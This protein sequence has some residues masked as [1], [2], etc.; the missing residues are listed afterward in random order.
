MK[1]NVAALALSLAA[2]FAPLSQAHAS[3]T[4]IAELYKE[5][6]SEERRAGHILGTL[7]RLGLAFEQRNDP[8]AG[9][10]DDKFFSD[11]P[12]FENLRELKRTIYGAYRNGRGNLN[13][14][15]VILHVVNQHCLPQQGTS[16]PNP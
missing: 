11:E 6:V 15:A 9:C 16:A 2:V 3:L 7:G 10:I 1:K 5:G 13:V 8:R 4:P 14:E 12:D